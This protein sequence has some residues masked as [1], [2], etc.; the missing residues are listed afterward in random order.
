MHY[1]F[2]VA[3]GLHVQLWS[4]NYTSSANLRNAETE[5]AFRNAPDLAS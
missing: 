4:F 1:K 5:V 3:D 2:M